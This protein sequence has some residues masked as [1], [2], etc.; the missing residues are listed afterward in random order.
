M[1]CF[2]FCLHQTTRYTLEKL[3]EVFEDGVVGKCR[4]I[5]IILTEIRIN[6]LVSGRCA[7]K[8]HSTRKFFDNYKH[9]LN[10]IVFDGSTQERALN[11]T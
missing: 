7:H 11:S 6:A 5:V 3:D 9:I 10:Y 2:H 4:L 1:G 8:Y